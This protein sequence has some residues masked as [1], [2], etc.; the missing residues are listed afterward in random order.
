MRLAVFG[1]TNRTKHYLVKRALDA[2]YAVDVLV[3]SGS[4]SGRKRQRLNTVIGDIENVNSMNKVLKN[5][6]AV[7]CLLHDVQNDF[8]VKTVGII[9]GLI[10]CMET[11]LVRRLV[12]FSYIKTETQ[13]KV[14]ENKGL[15]HTLLSTF[16][17]PN[18]SPR[19]IA[20]LLKETD[21]DWTIV[22]HPPIATSLVSDIEQPI[23]DIE[24]HS[25]NLAKQIV[26]QITDVGY[27]KD[28]LVLST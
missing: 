17:N 23:F 12:I 18:D 5:A 3:S 21:I 27:L 20:D 24:S 1:E 16:V 25:K 26:S 2:G 4:E 10:S 13:Q 9:K 8:D 19:N 28:T 7:I 15:L 6:D 11:N 14:P 22:G